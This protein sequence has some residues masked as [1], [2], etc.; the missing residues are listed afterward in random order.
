MAITTTY[1]G[2]E[3]RS[4][5]EARWAALFINLGW[6]IT[7]EPFDGDGY[8]PDFLIHG[9]RPLLVEVKPAVTPSEYRGAVTK[10]E[11]G[12][13]RHWKHDLL[14]VGADPVAPLPAA[15][16]FDDMPAAG[17]LGEADGEGW[18]WDAGRWFRCGNCHAVAIFHEYMTYAGRPCGCYS[19]DHYLTH[20]PTNILQNTWADGCNDVKWRGNSAQEPAVATSTRAPSP[21]LALFDRVRHPHFGEGLVVGLSPDGT[22][23][24]IDFG[25]HEGSKS[26]L[27]KFAPLVKIG[28]I[29]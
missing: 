19:G 15:Y 23:A 14:I 1:Q 4:R 17:L 25:V 18:Q 3:Y 26:L 22:S 29:A 20:L 27:L 10:S 12:L 16:G 8:I 9:E 11:N 2:I 7:Y 21:R 5:L 24:K 6:R 28:N 13:R